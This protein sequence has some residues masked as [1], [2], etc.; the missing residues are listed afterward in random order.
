MNHERPAK[1]KI[2]LAL[3][4]AL[5]PRERENLFTLLQV[6]CAPLAIAALFNLA[7]GLTTDR[8]RPNS[9]AT[10]EYFSLSWGRGLG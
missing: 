3:T 10:L 5:S 9:P 4:P 8:L 2:T 6:N 1:T 7:S